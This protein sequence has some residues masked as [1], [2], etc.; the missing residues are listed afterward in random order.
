LAV[1]QATLALAFA[2]NGRAKHLNK[3]LNEQIDQVMDELGGLLW[4]FN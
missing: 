1:D 3:L 2:A 4:S